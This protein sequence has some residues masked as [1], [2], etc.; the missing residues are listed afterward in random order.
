LAFRIQASP[1]DCTGCEVCVTTCPDNALKMVSME[2]VMA[3][4]HGENW[5]YAMQLPDRSDRFD[6]F[7]LKGSQFQQPLLEFSGACEGCGETPYAKLITQ[8]FGQ[9]LIVA[10]TTG[11]SSIWGGTAGWVPYTV[12]KDTGKGP[13]WGNSLFEDNAEYGLGMVLGMQ[14]RRKHLTAAVE[15]A[16]ANKELGD[17]MALINALEQWL[18]RKDDGEMSRQFGD[19]IQR[20]LDEAQTK[21][22]LPKDLLTV[23]RLRD[24]LTKPAMW[25][26]GGDGWANDIGFGGLDHAVALGENINI[27]VMDT[28]VYSNTGGQSSKATPL[29]SVAK[30]AQKGRRQQ[31]KDLGG[32]FM[33]YANVYVASVA[34]GANFQQTVRAFQEAE[35]HPGPSVVI[36][37]SP[38]IEHRTKTGMSQMGNDQRAAVEC[39]YWP[40]YRYDPKQE[41]LGEAAFQL[42]SKTITGKVTEF[43]RTQ[44][45]YAQLERSLPEDAEQLQKALNEHLVQRH[46][47]MKE[48]SEKKPLA[49]NTSKLIDGLKGPELYVLYGSETGTAEAVARKFA[50]TVKERNCTVKKCT[51]L[52]DMLE[53][54]TMDPSTFVLFVATCGDGH[55]PAN[56]HGFWEYAEKAAPGKF[57]QH[58]FAIFALGDKGYAKFC[59]AGKLFDGR[60][61]Q[62]GCQQVLPLGIGDQCDEDGWE[63][64]Y[65]AWLPEVLE[66]IKAPAPAKRDGPP[67]P[68]FKVVESP[69]APA[70]KPPQLC[71]PE[72]VL[73]E[74]QENRRMP[75]PD[76]E[77]D[78]RHFVLSNKDVDL[79]FHL[80]DAIGIYPQNLPE[81]VNEAL[82]FFGYAADA[83][84]NVSLLCDASDVHARLGAVSKQRTTARQLLTEVIDIFGR[85]SKGFYTQLADF[86]TD[87][88]EKAKILEIANGDG[89][90][91]LL[92][93]SVSYF[94]IFKKFPSAKP[95]L[96]HLMALIPPIKYRLYSIAN[97]A[98]FTPGCV[99]LTIVV[100]RWPTK[101]GVL[102]TG[103]STKYIAELPV[104]ARVAC[105]MTCG[106]FT[107]PEDDVPMVMS[108]L[109]T[110]IAPMRSFVQDRAYKK[111]V[112]GKKVGPMAL[113]YGCRHEREEFFYKE[114]WKQFQQDGVLT[115]LINA[116]SHDKPHYPPKMVFVNEKMEEN[117]ELIG[118]Y[119]GDL[120]GYFYMCGLAVAAPGI[121]TALKKAMIGA[122][123]V[124]AADADA[125]VEELK[126]T[127][128][129]SMESY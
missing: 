129:Y 74:V 42:D 67:A 29:G 113:F 97:S 37:Y 76:Y 100:N 54:E 125:W 20:I 44:N 68:L 112:L 105:T 91:A 92:E 82:A 66:A 72:A 120:G 1:M 26:F 73:A 98:D 64:G 27:M 128:R 16:L 41:A 77:R 18:E 111:K 61:K 56:A 47:I 65:S 70:L 94:D 115:H 49:Q 103:T 59:E 2:D 80:G 17:N 53:L 34:I 32:C 88:K 46:A 95:S 104:G 81:G 126:R 124:K 108:G 127:G 107:F 52:N 109:G 50:R 35:A 14:Q 62:L 51:E 71:P 24:V 122:K 101:S 83:P 21:A 60:L 33:H 23:S 45:R 28:E 19:E 25:M 89:Y 85:P 31:K 4:G 69:D 12:H 22:K 40:L 43:L 38:C 121:E 8:L 79:P 119:M 75:P 9:R 117:L 78:I 99:E 90:K 57:G 39:G 3:Q 118:K 106:T 84:L 116:F 7:S 30:F 93:E 6:K 114:E 36:C 5:K 86:A 96:A 48:R 15:S 87:A 123:H 13:A 63:T 11:C 110:G 55:I 58:K 10:N 102:K